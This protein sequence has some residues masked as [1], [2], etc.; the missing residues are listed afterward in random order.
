MLWRVLVGL[1]TLAVAS[2]ATGCGSAGDDTTVSR[3]R[4]EVEMQERY[5]TTADEAACITG[6]VYDEYDGTAIR[7]LYDEGVTALPQAV[8]DPFVHSVIGCT[9]P[10]GSLEP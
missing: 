1:S 10:D 2:V 8:W 3:S 9:I 7:A 5:A 6:F 4:F